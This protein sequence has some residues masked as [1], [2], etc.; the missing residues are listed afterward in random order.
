MFSKQDIEKYFLAE[1]QL[2]LSFIIIGAIAIVL[3]IVFFFL[4]KTPFYKGAA[5]PLLIIGLI[6]LVAS[7]TIYKKSDADRIRNV[8]AYDMN[9]VRI[10]NEE[11][12]RMKTVIKNFAII[13]WVEIALVVTGLLMIFYYRADADKAFWYGL[14]L[15]LTIQALVMLIADYAAERRALQYTRGIESLVNRK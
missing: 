13:K 10:K 7:I 4:L 1:K 9:P 12:P 14:G 3:A 6:Q 8:Y 15:T 2:G 5:I 11:L